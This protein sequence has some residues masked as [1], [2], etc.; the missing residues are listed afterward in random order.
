MNENFFLSSELSFNLYNNMAKKM[1]I[2]DY[3][4]HLSVDDIKNDRMFSDLTELWILSDPYKARAMRICGIDEAYITGDADNYSKFIKWSEVLPQLVGNPL[5]TW[6]EMELNRI[7]GIKEQL[8]PQNADEI[9]HRTRDMLSLPAYSNNEILSRFNIRYNSP[10]C[11]ITDD[12]SFF[13]GK[14]QMSPSLRADNIVNVD[15]E[16]IK[17]LSENSATSIESLDDYMKAVSILIDQFCVA[18]CK[19][20]DH[21]LD[22]NFMY[23]SDDG[24]NHKRFLAILEGKA[25]NDE[26]IISLHSYMLLKLTNEYAKRNITMLLH[27]GAQRKTSDRL[28]DI[29]GPAGG[30]AAIGQPCNISSVINLLNDSEKVS[31]PKTVLFTLNPADCASFSVLSGSFSENNVRAKIQQ[32]PAWWWCD[33]SFGIRNVLECINAYGVLSTFIGMTTDSRSILSFVRHEY[34]RRILCGWIG[35]KVRVGEMPDKYDL[36]EDI[37]RKICYENASELIMN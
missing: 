35:E 27:I 4:N 1:P 37:V 5:Y 14:S 12:V 28:F 20:S 22:N 34:F 30:Y 16:F 19:F 25:L 8:T 15:L 17:R 10:C 32:G 7:F 9:W 26:D 13:N 29:A 3:H 36:L 21:A 2:I 18:G 11:S 6:S 33:H 24:N 31:M 23:V